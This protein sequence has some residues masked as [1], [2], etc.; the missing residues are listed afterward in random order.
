M[1]DTKQAGAI[2]GR[3]GETVRTW[4]EEFKSYLSPT[5]T[6]GKGRKRIF[7]GD[8]MSV[9]SLVAE[10]KDHGYTYAQI[11]ENLQRGER[12]VTPDIEPREVDALITT[13]TERRLMLQVE[14][15]QKELTRAY[16]ERDSALKKA[17]YAHELEIKVAS[18][19][20]EVEM[21]R[22]QAPSSADIAKLYETIGELR[23]E[24]KFLRR[25]WD[26]D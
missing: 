1:Y 18:L 12:G 9:F 25:G 22:S 16:Q 4:S 2:F 3:N 13:D 7:N 26:G 8:D 14:N 23:G 19:E 17:E 10:L 21:L 24:I 15:F 11:H 6:P 20:K 5:A